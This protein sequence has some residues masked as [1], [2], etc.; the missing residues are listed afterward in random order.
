MR[1]ILL[2]VLLPLV[3]LFLLIRI[4]QLIGPVPTIALCV[5]TGIVGAT[6]TRRTGRSI[7]QRM[8]GEMAQG[9]VPARELVEGLMVLVSGV[10]LLTPG[11]LTDLA[12]FLLLIGPVRRRVA[13]VL[14]HIFRGRVQV[15]GFGPGGFAGFGGPGGFGG[16]ESRDGGFEGREDPPSPGTDPGRGP[17]S[18]G[19]GDRREP[20]DVEFEHGSES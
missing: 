12:G 7:L 13:G 4:G 5:V 16:P 10:V 3:E 11:V 8:Q 15:G 6:L 2:F 14:I 9:R 1:L 17:R 18:R 20:R 19:P